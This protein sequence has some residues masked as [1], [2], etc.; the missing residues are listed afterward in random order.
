M[1]FKDRRR[2]L[3]VLLGM[4]LV[5]HAAAIVTASRFLDDG[6]PHTLILIFIVL[7]VTCVVDIGVTRQLFG[8]LKR[9][10]QDYDADVSKDLEESLRMYTSRALQDRR[11]ASSVGA[12]VERSIAS[13]R[14]AL[15]EGDVAGTQDRL[16]SGIDL[17]SQ[18]WTTR[19][20]NVVVASVL[21]SKS[22]QCEAAGFELVAKVVL[23]EILGIEDVEVAAVFFNLI[24]NALHECEELARPGARI[25]VQA[26]VQAGQLFVEVT[27]PCRGGAE[28]RRR[29]AARRADATMY[30]GL[31]TSIVSDIA[32]RHGGLAQFA[33]RDGT[34]V[35]NVIIPADDL[36]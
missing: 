1:R 5:L 7:C 36:R 29:V 15:M 31:G 13:A 22:R 12:S 2:L 35:A 25:E 3:G 11:L 14:Q 18:T 23:P 21:E 34:F 8:A 10:E 32:Q 19:C 6:S 30:H 28:H 20:D 24:D 27:N 17:V 4:M 26:R 9:L 33:E 16:R